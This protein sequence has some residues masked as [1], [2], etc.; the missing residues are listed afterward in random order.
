MLNVYH[1]LEVNPVRN[2]RANAEGGRAFANYLV[3]LEVQPLIRLFG[4]K[5]FGQPLFVPAA[6]MDE[7]N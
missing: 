5:D 1:V 4:V 2:P 6:G 3:S 7:P